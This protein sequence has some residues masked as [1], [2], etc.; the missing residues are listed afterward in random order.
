MLDILA[1]NPAL[2]AVLSAILAALIAALI[3]IPVM[4][5]AFRRL[6]SR[7]KEQK[8]TAESITS[9]LQMN[10]SATQNAEQ[11]IG[12]LG[13]RINARMDEMS[14]SNQ[15]QLAEMRRVVDEQL[16][17]TLETRIGKS[18]EA[19]NAQLEK[20][21]RGLGEMQALATGVGDLKKVMQGVKTRGIWGEIQLGALLEQVLAPNQYEANAAVTPGSQE[22]VEY[23]VRLPGRDGEGLLL[24]IDS[25]FPVECFYRLNEASEA[26]DKAAI[27]LASNELGRAVQ[28]EAKKIAQK[29]IK[30]PVTT[31]FALMFL[32][33]ESLYAEVLR[34]PGLAEA[35][36][37]KSRVI[38]SGPAT[39]SALLMSLQMGFKTL[40]I[41]QRSGEVIS[42]LSQVKADFNRFELT[43]D[44][45]R[46]KL[47]Q[48]I[49]E[50][51][52]AASKTK[53]ITRRL[54]DLERYE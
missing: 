37:L 44:N 34:I 29:Y 41:E 50:L 31:D 11:R 2:A 15:R 14:A 20:V 23:A 30:P 49:G 45:T 46:K 42:L 43:L 51:D 7:M 22:R 26:G 12:A 16:Q 54:E 6:A 40:A 18:F 28:D 52:S 5:G 38:I 32:P 10:A 21:Y 36:Q 47:E 19:V 35:V 17:N 53:A 48:A 39:L 25:K 24:P 3:I 27:T 13:D 4:R 8:I 33:V 9:V 1:Q